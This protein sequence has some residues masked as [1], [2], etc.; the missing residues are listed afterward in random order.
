MPPRAACAPG[1]EAG[2]SATRARRYNVPIGFRAMKGRTPVTR[3]LPKSLA[4]VRTVGIPRGL[5]QHRYGALWQTFFEALGRTVVLSAK[6]DRSLVEEGSL[7]SVDECCLAS[8]AY[9][10]HVASLAGACDAVF[11]P[12]YASANP[13]AGFCTK[14]QSLPD[15]VENALR[16]RGVRIVTLLVED[17]SDE[18]RTREA[19]LD[20]ARRFGASPREARRA[21]KEAARAQKASDDARAAHQDETLSLLD[22]YR[23]VLAHDAAGAEQQPLS[24]LLAAHP[25]IAHDRY[26]SGTVVDAL[27][28]AGA[29]VLFADETDHAKAFK[30]S[31]GFSETMPW[32]VNREL[33]GSIL[34]LRDRIDGIV[35]VSAF[36]CGP[37]SMTDD[38]IMRCIQGTPILGLTIDAQ[39]GSAGVQT[40][41]ESFVDIL[42]FKQKGGYVHGR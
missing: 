2:A 18:R 20:L 25:Y 37:D 9:L 33:I 22:E 11:V 10:G 38:A 19:Y 42:R 8:K 13:R 12:A 36:P 3:S 28:E 23:R 6:T 29:T 41:V 27:E 39:S 21:W 35:L 16:D 14:F 30:A 7:L 31:L 34:L 5:L 17:A 26:L 4:D 32:A 40:R 15:L 24:V 1:P